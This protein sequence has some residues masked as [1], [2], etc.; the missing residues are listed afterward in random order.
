MKHVHYMCGAPGIHRDQPFA[1]S[2]LSRQVSVASLAWLVLLLLLACSV[3]WSRCCSGHG[4]RTSVRMDEEKKGT[5]MDNVGLIGLGLNRIFWVIQ[6]IW[7]D[8]VGIFSENV[9][10]NIGF[11][12]ESMWFNVISCEKTAGIWSSNSIGIEESGKT[13]QPIWDFFE[14]PYMCTCVYWPCLVGP[15]VQNQHVPFSFDFPWLFWWLLDP[16]LAVAFFGH[17]L[18]AVRELAE[19]VIFPISDRFVRTLNMIEYGYGI[20]VAATQ[21]KV[22]RSFLKCAQPDCMVWMC[23]NVLFFPTKWLDVHVS[24]TCFAL[25]CQ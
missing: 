2:R 5:L 12:G 18:V 9:D 25:V 6:S 22:L 17:I 4:W 1:R 19:H 13:N 8:F 10:E 24:C 15:F 16:C 21:T 7:R 14:L 23:V 20:W 11:N 3:N